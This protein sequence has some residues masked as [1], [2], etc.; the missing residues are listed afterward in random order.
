MLVYD[1]CSFVYRK[2]ACSTRRFRSYDAIEIKIRSLLSLISGLG[3]I[4]VGTFVVNN[5]TVELVTV[6]L[7][8]LDPKINGTTVVQ[9]SD[10]HL[11]PFNGKARL[12][13]V[14]E[15]VN[16]LQGDIV[17]ITGDLVDASVKDLKEAVVPLKKLKA[18]YGV[19]YITGI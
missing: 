5:L 1:M 18:R 7:K 8:G 17:V 10:I 2:V 15:K 14:V 6:P 16:Q 11:G 12:N 19:Y 13:S 9:I 4:I 3:L